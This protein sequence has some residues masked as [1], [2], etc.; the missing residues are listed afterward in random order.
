MDGR[1]EPSTRVTSAQVEQG[2]SMEDC[3]TPLLS[4]T[5]RRCQHHVLCP[6][7]EACLLRTC[8]SHGPSRP[9]SPCAA[10]SRTCAPGRLHA[11]GRT[12]SGLQPH[13]ISR[14]DE[15]LFERIRGQA[16]RDTDYSF[17]LCSVLCAPGE[18]VEDGE[19]GE[20]WILDVLHCLRPSRESSFFWYC[21]AS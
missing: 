21:L 7:S 10:F 18:Y 8:R 3:T 12:S 17:I 5:V 16:H 2:T 20:K 14:S 9:V 15:R 19:D 6:C 1:A 11:R 4:Y 13:L